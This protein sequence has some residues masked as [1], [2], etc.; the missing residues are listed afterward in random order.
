MTTA[1][2]VIGAVGWLVLTFGAAWLGA[3]FIPDE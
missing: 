2:A 1:I 3:R